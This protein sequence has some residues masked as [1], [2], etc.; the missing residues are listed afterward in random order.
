MKS[1]GDTV[2]KVLVTEPD[3]V[4]QDGPTKFGAVAN[5]K[6]LWYQ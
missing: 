6:L 1:H 5:V 2:N 4:G 3:K